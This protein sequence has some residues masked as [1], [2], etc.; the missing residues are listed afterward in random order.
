MGPRIQT[1]RAATP[2]VELT[3][4]QSEYHSFKTNKSKTDAYRPAE[5]H[6]RPMP[7]G[8]KRWGHMASARNT[9]KRGDCKMDIAHYEVPGAV[10]SVADKQLISKAL[11]PTY[12]LP[13]PEFYPSPPPGPTHKSI[14]E[15]KGR[16]RG[17]LSTQRAEHDHYKKEN[18][19]LPLQATNKPVAGTAFS[20]TGVSR[21]LQLGPA[22]L[23]PPLDPLLCLF[24]A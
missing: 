15:V 21:K 9:Q 1:P 19:A 4:N 8:L 10:L 18:D 3:A 16:F 14:N 6:A 11:N 5:F 24:A 12:P 22:A 2:R 23:T 17:G 7:P 20:N 13:K